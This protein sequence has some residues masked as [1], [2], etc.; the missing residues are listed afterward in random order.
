MMKR[1]MR[2]MTKIFQ[3]SR[4]EDAI[5]DSRAPYRCTKVGRQY[6]N[7]YLNKVAQYSNLVT[8]RKA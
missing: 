5:A 2:R 6:F 3:P 7:M 8:M 1:I 4:D